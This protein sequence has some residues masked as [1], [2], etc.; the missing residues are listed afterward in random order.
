MSADMVTE[1]RA[2]VNIENPL[3]KVQGRRDQYGDRFWSWPIKEWDPFVPGNDLIGDLCRTDAENQARLG[4]YA[5]QLGSC[6]I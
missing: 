1:Q 3:I 6:N 2:G 4:R 5:A